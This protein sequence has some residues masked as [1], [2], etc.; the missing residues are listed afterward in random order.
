MP[1]PAAIP[2]G[3]TRL[4]DVEGIDAVKT[5]TDNHATIVAL[6]RQALDA[7]RLPPQ[8]AGLGPG[9]GG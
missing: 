7:T 4:S 1:E 6:I 2:P 9:A 8:L 5:A 3:A